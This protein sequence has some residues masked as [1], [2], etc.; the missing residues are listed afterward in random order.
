MPISV[1]SL[2]QLERQC[3][4]EKERAAEHLNTVE[5][6]Y[7]RQIDK[8]QEQLKSVE[9]ERNLMMVSSCFLQVKCKVNLISGASANDVSI[10][11]ALNW[12]QNL[13]VRNI[14]EIPIFNTLPMFES[15]SLP[16]IIIRRGKKAKK[17]L[18]SNLVIIN[19]A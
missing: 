11:L 14:V 9:K 19:N 17:M 1:V 3:T 8:L 12:S 15:F 16:H 10:D 5:E 7:Q 6:H 18:Y 4:R 13:H 2:R